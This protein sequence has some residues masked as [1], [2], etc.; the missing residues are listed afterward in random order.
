M[1][2]NC[3]EFKKCGREIGGAKAGELGICPASASSGNDGVHGGKNS[4]RICWAV[5]GTFCGGK[6]QGEF[7]NKQVTCMKCDFFKQVLKE[8]KNFHLLPPG[9][10][11]KI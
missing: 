3:W 11:Y 7:V 10:T 6:I 2:Q 4:G 1:K 5:A 8:E 9:K